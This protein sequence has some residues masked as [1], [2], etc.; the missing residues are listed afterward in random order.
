MGVA[1]VTLRNIG[2]KRTFDRREDW[3]TPQA[4]FDELNSVFRFD[5]DACANEHNRKCDRFYSKE[6]DALRQA[7]A[8]TVWCNPPYGRRV[9]LFVRKA[10][11]ESVKG[12]TVVMLLPASTD[13]KW[14]HDYCTRATT[15]LLRGRL[16]FVGARGHAPF[17]SAVVIFWGG[18]LGES[19][20][21]NP[22][23]AF[24]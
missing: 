23:A 1:D 3:G 24:E 17:A 6:T 8:G 14:W 20:R 13:T 7:W 19:I 10:F 18:V 16:T 11:V 22:P 2:A 9:A 12:A 21:G 5:L 15:I 4:L